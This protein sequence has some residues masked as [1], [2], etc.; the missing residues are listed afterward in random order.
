MNN[1]A[2]LIEEYKE[3]ITKLEARIEELKE[4]RK[5]LSNSMLSYRKK[6]QI[7]DLSFRIAYL[8]DEINLMYDSIHMM[9]GYAA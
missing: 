7:E 8:E 5:Q 9:K 4:Q 6:E 3:G 1:Y 2:N